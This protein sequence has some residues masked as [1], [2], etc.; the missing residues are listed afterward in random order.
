MQEGANTKAVVD[1]DE[2]L[3][4]VSLGYHAVHMQQGA[5]IAAALHIAAH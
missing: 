4:E 3:L 1:N 5:D 2:A